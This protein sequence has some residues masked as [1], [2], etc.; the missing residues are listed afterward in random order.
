VFLAVCDGG[1]SASRRHRTASR[2]PLALCWRNLIAC[3]LSS[4]PIAWP[5][6]TPLG[7]ASP[8][9][10]PCYS[11]L[12]TRPRGADLHSTS[13]VAD[14][15]AGTGGDFVE[16]SRL[17]DHNGSKESESINERAG[18]SAGALRPRPDR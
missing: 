14:R 16:T 4:R 18:A 1:G 5:M 15:L 7:Q 11:R 3:R 2:R 8:R 6:V 17:D 12:P 10:Q 9:R 13:A